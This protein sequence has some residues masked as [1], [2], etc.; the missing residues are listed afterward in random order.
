M[1]VVDFNPIIVL[2]LTRSHSIS[3]TIFAF[4]SYYSLI[5]N[6][7]AS[8][9]SLKDCLFQSYYSLISNLILC[10]YL[11]LN[12]QYFNPIIVLFLTRHSGN[13]IIIFLSFQSYYSLISNVVVVVY[14]ILLLLI[15]ILL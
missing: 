8:Y 5:S 15:S 7:S 9:F 3:S 4:Q 12:L 2:F 6:N 13:K 14:N 11:E 1:L 10:P